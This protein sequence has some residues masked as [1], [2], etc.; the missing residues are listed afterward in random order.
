MN[1]FEVVIGIENH[2]ELKTKSKMFCT[3]PVEY[4]ATPNTKVSETDLGYPGALPTVNKKGVE[5]AI[6]AVNALGM[7]LDSKLRFDRK[8]YFYPDLAKG[9]QITQQF[10]PI[11]KR[12]KIEIEL[13]NGEKKTITVERIHIE[14]DTAKQTHKDELTFLDYNRSGVGLIEIVSDPVIRSAEEAVAYVEKLREILLFSE[15]S[16][17]KMN[18]GSLRCDINISLRPIGYQGFGTKVE[19][20]NL[21]SLSNIKKSIEFEIKRQTELLLNNEPIAMET[22]RFDEGKQ[23]TILMRTKTD[24]VDYRYF[25]EPNIPPIQLDVNWIKEV[26]KSAPELA[27]VKRTRY[28]KEF[29]IKPDEINQILSSLEINQFFEAT[30]KYT[31]NYSKVANLLLGDIQSLLNKD[32]IEIQNAKIKPKHIGELLSLIDEGVISSKHVKTILP[33]LIQN[34]GEVNKIIDDNNLKQISDP[35]KIEE[36][37]KPIFDENIELLNQFEKR[38][39]RVTKTL[40]GQ[41]MKETG[42]N[43]NPDVAQSIILQ[44]IEKYIKK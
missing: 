39:E 18:E 32:E 16:D 10:Y 28:A 35:F 14:E 20:K 8:S 7:K 29:N 24:A 34:G 15:I 17:V 1:N 30:L 25:R 3:G 36:Y 2:V 6:L 9:F 27:D 4:G 44:M 38:P 41:L 42:G 33:I 26:I 37:L 23:E 5:L 19:I 21:N 22:R 13:S 43:V 12:G 31:K 11:G 40:M